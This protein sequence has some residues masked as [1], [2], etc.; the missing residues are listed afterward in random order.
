MEADM[1]HFKTVLL[2]LLVVF[3]AFI[4]VL[5]CSADS[6]EGENTDAGDD[7]GSGDADT[8]AGAKFTLTSAAFTDGGAI[9]LK[10]SCGPESDYRK[11]SLP[12][13]WSNAPAGTESF[14]LLF[15]DL[16]E[17]ADGWVHWLVIDIPAAA[18]SLAAGAGGKSMPTGA[19]ELKN[20]WGESAYG[21]P[22]PPP[23]T[24]KHTYRV[25][26]FAM[27]DAQTSVSFDGRNGRQIT[28]TLKTRALG[29][30]TLT[31]TYDRSGK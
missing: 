21:G 30:A 15:D 9:P 6:G 17:V 22:C 23:P 12:L 24:G 29:I 19:K 4:G 26:L 14:V 31:G 16:H 28:E 5:N 13:A 27:P 18:T 3:M 8:G 20:S 11:P 2:P 25:Q 1:R 10:N 7:S